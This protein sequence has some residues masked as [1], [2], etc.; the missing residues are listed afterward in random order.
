MSQRL[1]K[2]MTYCV[3]GFIFAACLVSPPPAAAQEARYTVMAA[4]LFN[5]LLFTDWPA[6]DVLD[7]GPYVI[8][9]I[10]SNPFERAAPTLEQRNAG[11][12]DIRFAHFKT[13]KDLEPVHI[14]FVTA[15]ADSGL[16]EIREALKESPV[17]LV[18]ESEDFTQRGGVIRFFEEAT[19][20]AR[21]ETTLRVEINRPSAEARR[22][23]FRSQLLRLAQV[24]DYPVP[25]D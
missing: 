14:L 22:I 5:F 13:R 11:G 3:A 6:H 1:S 15:E 17:L 10:G 24:V 12:R 2:T 7:S 4:F 9:V 16:H 18:G 8:G 19:G 23:R 21:T 25:S 20:A